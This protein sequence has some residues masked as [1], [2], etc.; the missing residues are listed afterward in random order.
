MGTIPEARRVE[1]ETVL[2]EHYKQEISDE[3]ID[4]AAS[5]NFLE[6]NGE[7][8]PHSRAVVQHYLESDT[9]GLLDLEKMWRK[10]F[11][12]T[13]KPQHLP[14]LWSVDH[15]ADRLA[16]K[17]KENRI[18]LDQYKLATEGTSNEEAFDL[19]AYRSIKHAQLGVNP[20]LDESTVND[21]TVCDES[22]NGVRDT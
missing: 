7:Y 8:V 1:L 13:M 5:A 9:V 18:D 14:D 19:E 16:V 15:Q 20:L 2:T 21:N 22:A 4:L 17:A 10:H 12:K 11:L 6:E 3:I